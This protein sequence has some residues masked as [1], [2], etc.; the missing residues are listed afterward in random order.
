MKI[1]VIQKKKIGDVLTST[2]I[3]EAIKEKHP[4][5]ELNYL[6]FSNSFSVV[7]NNPFIDKLIV[8]EEK[9]ST[10]FIGFLKLVFQ[11]RK[12]KYDVIIDVY[13]KF[14]SLLL[15]F[16]IGSKK[17]IAFEKNYSKILFTDLVKRNKKS[18]SIA[19]KAV[20]HRLILLK[21]LGI[22]FKIFKPKI[23]LSENEKNEARLSLINAG[24][25]TEN[26]IV[27]ISAIGSEEIKT[28]PL[29]YLAKVINEIALVDN[30][31]ILLNYIPFQRKEVEKLYS[32]CEK[33]TQKKIFL[34]FY[35]N[36]LRKFIAVT[37]CCNALIGNEGGATNI[38]KAIEISTF[39]LFSPR[40]LKQD[41]NMFENETTNISI[42]VYDYFVPD[43]KQNDFEKYRLFAPELFKDKL[44]QFLNFNCRS[45]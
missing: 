35:E 39:T 30:I 14:N 20:E 15:G 41:W 33:A 32:L 29:P 31:Q 23:F 34:N 42:H 36:D 12:E 7:K 4:N 38:A 43:P 45:L 6:I 1:L 28:Y 5:W 22:N 11:L 27:M 17:R 37:S 25:S 2:V 13:S 8:L 40:I 19:T 3:F 44:I 24:I 9:D 10:S 21:P 18:F 26:P 16:L